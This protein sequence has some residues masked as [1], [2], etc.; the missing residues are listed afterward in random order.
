MAAAATRTILMPSPAPRGHGQCRHSAW[1]VRPTAR[2]HRPR[3][4]VW[5][6]RSSCSP[7]ARPSVYTAATRP[8]PDHRA[9]ASARLQRLVCTPGSLA[10]WWQ[11]YV[12]GGG[13]CHVSDRETQSMGCE[14]DLLKILLHTISGPREAA[15]NGAA[16]GEA[17]S[18][19]H[20]GRGSRGQPKQAKKSPRPAQNFLVRRAHGLR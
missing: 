1:W 4:A 11:A 18:P 9:Q 7:S 10:L 17:C 16:L 5:T 13:P 14:N 3:P 2:S 15:C 12:P 6:R 19:N 20:H 8:R